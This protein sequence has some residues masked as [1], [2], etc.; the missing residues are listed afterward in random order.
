MNSLRGITSEDLYQIT[1]VNDP[2]PS[3]QDGQLVYVSRQTNEAR[4]GY[5][6][7]LRLLHLGSQKDRPFTFGDKDHSPAWSPDG[8]Q[9]AF[10][11]EVDR[12]S[13][14][15][16]IPSD[17]GEAQQISHL[18][19]GVSSLLWSPDGRTILVKSSV[20]MT[21]QEESHSTNSKPDTTDDNKLPQELVVNR[22][23]MKSDGSGL[24]D[25][26]RTHLFAIVP[27]SAEATL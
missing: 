25:G 19:H 21:N 26:K 20:D 8:S 17:G 23:R 15:W 13:Q 22:I 18:E 24:W 16:L 5:C 1:W 14:V 11:R 27:L 7:H 3:P 10:I 9:L 12:K 4:D 6:S 2:T